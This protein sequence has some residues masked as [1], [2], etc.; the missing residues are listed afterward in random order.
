LNQS[1]GTHVIEEF[2]VSVGISGEFKVG[3]TGGATGGTGWKQRGTSE[4]FAGCVGGIG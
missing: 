2:K 1:G 4:G 3:V